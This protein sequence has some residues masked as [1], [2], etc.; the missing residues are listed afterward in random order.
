MA[1]QVGELQYLVEILDKNSSKVLDSISGETAN[2]TKELEKADKGSTKFS[3]SFG[4]AQKASTNFA[5]G[6]GVAVT[7]VAAA[8]AALGAFA[9]NE[10]SEFQSRM[11]DINTLLGLSQE[12]LKGFGDQVLEISNRVPVEGS[13]LSGSL[14]D[15]VSAGISDTNDALGVLEEASRLGIAGLGD[16]GSAANLLTSSLNAFQIS[17]DD[18]G[19]V[20]DILFKTVKNGKTTIDEISQSFGQVAPV[21]KATGVT[22]EELQAA[23]AAL[24]TSGLQ[25]SVAQ[26]QLKALFVELT[27]EGTKLDKAF[28]KIGISNVKAAVEAD[29][30]VDTLTRLQKESNLSDVELQNLFGSVEAGGAAIALLGA[31]NKAFVGTLEDMKNGA[32]AVNAAFETQQQTFENQTRLLQNQFSQILINIGQRILPILTQAVERLSQFLADN[33]ETITATVTAATELAGVIAG[34]LFSAFEI[35]LNV[36]GGV[37]KFFKDNEVAFY[38]LAGAITSA[39]IPAATALSVTLATT[40]VPAIIATVTAL[41]PFIA[42][43]AAIG[44]A[45]FA[46]KAAFDNNFLGIRDIVEA[47]GKEVQ[48]WFAIVSE[49]VGSVIG[50]VGD[51]FNAVGGF[52]GGIASFFGLAGDSAQQNAETIKAATSESGQEILR[53]QQEGVTALTTLQIQGGD[54]TAELANRVVENTTKMSEVATTE[55]EKLRDDGIAAVEELRRQGIIESDEFA[56]QT[57]E[58]IQKNADE[59]IAAFTERNARVLEINRQLSDETITNREELNSE[60]NTLLQEQA[61]EALKITDQSSAEQLAQL[62]AFKEGALILTE[63]QIQEQAKLAIENRDTQIQQLQETT[64]KRVELLQKAADATTGATKEEYLRLIK[65]QEAFNLQQIQAVKE[66]SNETLNQ[67]LKAGTEQGQLLDKNTGNFLS[68]WETVKKINETQGFLAAEEFKKTGQLVSDGFTTGFSGIV[69]K[70]TSIVDS[71]VAQIKNRA[72]QGLEIQSPSKVFQEIGK[73]TADGFALGINIGQQGALNVMGELV[74]GLKAEGEKAKESIDFTDVFRDFSKTVDQSFKDADAAVK[75]FA[76]SNKE[77]QTDIVKD[78]EKV[79]NEIA[80]LSENFANSN[81]RAEESFQSDAIKIVVDAREKQL[82]IEK[83]IA[84]VQK[85]QAQNA[86]ATTSEE[87]L[88]RQNERLAELQKQLGEAQSVLQ[89]NQEAGIVSTEQIAEAERVANLDPLTALIERFNAE[90]E[91]RQQKFDEELQQLEEQK[92]AL[93]ESLAARREEYDNFVTTLEGADKRFTETYKSQV[94]EREKATVDSISRQIQ[95]F[96]NLFAAQQRIQSQAGVTTGFKAGGFTG[97]ADGG[98]TG[99][100]GSNDV[101]GVVHKGEWVGP[102]WMVQGMPSLFRGLEAL[103]GG[104][105]SQNMAAPQKTVNVNVTNNGTEKTSLW[106]NAAYLRFIGNYV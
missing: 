97:F 11:S 28:N 5:K 75:E 104:G 66:T 95:A 32:N 92:V 64:D 63:D 21:A 71:M 1:I 72:K 83:Q 103:R 74:D 42:I 102:K 4:D 81:Q 15:I 37:I 69:A 6:V 59:Q 24:T 45:I 79:N 101:A 33:E 98:F 52:F 60:L 10:A 18:A 57:I 88:A 29:G 90:K 96:N 19:K 99:S 2:L 25:T 62:E 44:A 38:A 17:A 16:T 40:V 87:Q 85:E 51:A 8:G 13:V 55:L 39:L 84:E 53:L 3:K 27:R 26:T 94:A 50:I 80:K 82:A 61:F 7:A 54:Q 49:V 93:E 22:F 47:F 31:Q 34:A 76:R 73:F 70:A 20:S 86:T 46:L 9:V 58:N 35:I 30:F 91:A 43:G 23:T 78:L 65:E 12:E 77:A 14:Y 56:Q 106:A 67:L 36:V 68:Y 41:A 100:G 89:A 48:F 105:P